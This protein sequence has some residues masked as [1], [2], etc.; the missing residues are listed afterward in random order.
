M[1]RDRDRKR[2]NAAG[3]RR[4]AGIYLTQLGWLVGYP[5]EAGW[6]R[7]ED[8][9]VVPL[10]GAAIAKAR[11][12]ARTVMREHPDGL[13]KLVDVAPWWKI[14][15]AKLSW[16][17]AALTGKAGAFDPLPLLPGRLATTVR[18][19][20]PT[21]IGMAVRAAAIAFADRPEEL[22]QLIAWLGEHRDLVIEHDL[23]PSWRVVFAL[24]RLAILGDRGKARGIRER[25][26][27]A[28]I[29]L[30]EVDAPDGSAALQ[31]SRTVENGLR[32]QATK[33][34]ILEPVRSRPHVVPWVVRL[35]TRDATH[36]QRALS[37]VAEARLAEALILWQEWELSHEV[38]LQR[39][40]ALAE[41]NF[42][43]VAERNKAQAKVIIKIEKSRAAAPAQVSI[44]DAL[45]ELDM[46]GAGDVFARTQPAIVRL[47]AAL[48]AAWG[49]AGPGRMLLH[50]AR[51]AAT[52]D[53][54]EHFELVWDALADALD[55]GAPLSLLDPWK[56]VLT[57]D[58]RHYIESDILEHAKR[59]ADV[60]RAIRVLVAIAWTG[61]LG[62]SDVERSGIWL[63]AGLP[64]PRVPDVIAATRDIDGWMLVELAHAILAIADDTAEISAL[65]KRLLEQVDGWRHGAPKALAVLIEHAAATGGGWLIRSEIEDKHAES[66][67]EIGEMLTLLPRARWPRMTR[68]VQSPWIAHY[69]TSLHSALTKLAGVD[70]D[71]ERTTAK[72]LADDV[73]D[74][75]ALREEIAALR[76]R[77]DKPG[78]A[79]RL[80]NLEDR[81][82]NPKPPSKARLDNLAAK[83]ERSARDIGLARFIRATTEGA[84]ERILRAFGLP[85]LPAWAESP[86]T[87]ALLMSL[88][89]LGEGDR[90]LAGRLI[91][92]RCGDRPWDLRDEPA[93]R[94][95]LD[96]LRR[97]NIDPGP[98]LDDTPR[99][100]GDITLE[101]TGDPIEV[102]AMGAHFGTCLS[103]GG[104][105]FFSVVVNAADVNKRVIYAKRDGRVTGR[106]L[107]ALTDTFAILIFNV[108]SHENLGLDTQVHD[109]VLELATKMGTS[110]V[111]RGTVR[112][113]LGRDWYDDGPRDLVGR[114]RGLDDAGLD[115][116]AIQPANL[117]GILRSA[118]EHEI[119]DVTLPVILGHH[120]LARR[121][122][123]IFPLAPYILASAAPLTHFLAADLALRAGDRVLA[124]RLLG[125]HAGVVR[126]VD[127]TWH[128]GETLAELRPSF[129]LARLRETRSK[130]VRTWEDE[131]GDRCAVAGVALE[132]LHRPKQAVAMYKLALREDWLKMLLHDR[133][134]RLGEL[135]D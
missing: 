112:L 33:P 70:P 135:I 52:A 3:D 124:D 9:V 65:T 103:P 74:P 29:R 27:D 111:P 21:R 47:L 109:F 28:L 84:S 68:D 86:K 51:M 60:Q 125:E 12:T 98:W 6:R 25:G 61:A 13:A 88:L 89:S 45:L 123:L 46:L 127:H 121:P 119:D 75:K 69:P 134:K 128:H 56:G 10:D 64:E 96:E 107:I 48:P 90:E 94:A 34:R 108:Y 76:L 40:A 8:D 77:L 31:A 126:L 67:H 2:T 22:A 102:F 63:A 14:V 83:L 85:A 35:A 105:N 114:F 16:M 80:A 82:A 15:D 91:R 11:R 19:L 122:E 79:K 99:T 120:G 38:L 55:E 117:V 58:H 23:V 115:F 104:G 73:P 42:E 81:L 62:D 118:L 71:A 133:M 66:L 43:S 24:A 37:L 116:D 54:D 18:G 20:L 17:S 50:T 39:A 41:S 26:V 49:V 129:T 4:R 53:D 36:R 110:V 93:N 92:A 32:R 1:T 106:C 78:V 95:F 101:L 44:K 113:L 5:D 130:A 87:L 59:R 131:P 57:S 7:L 97:A 30:C 72:R 100:I 132:A